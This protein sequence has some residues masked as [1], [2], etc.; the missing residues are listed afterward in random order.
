MWLDILPTS[1]LPTYFL[2]KQSKARQQLQTMVK[3]NIS[4]PNNTTLKEK[5]FLDLVTKLA[6]FI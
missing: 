2:V 4:R 1:R 6:P 3:L 5:Q